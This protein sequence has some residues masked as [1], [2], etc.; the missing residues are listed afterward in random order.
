MWK[1]PCAFAILPHTANLQ[2]DHELGEKS[3]KQT[4]LFLRNLAVTKIHL[5]CAWCY[6]FHLLDSSNKLSNCGHS[7]SKRGRFSVPTEIYHLPRVARLVAEFRLSP[8]QI[9]VLSPLASLQRQPLGLFW[10]QAISG[11]ASVSCLLGLSSPL[12][13]SPWHVFPL[14]QLEPS[15]APCF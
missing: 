6:F 12:S 10:I 5:K 3:F 11:L 15:Q 7:H 14:K 8:W 9:P 2:A 13:S 4:F 1:S